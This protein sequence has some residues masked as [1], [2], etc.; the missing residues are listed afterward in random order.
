M[1]AVRLPFAPAHHCWS[2]GEPIDAFRAVGHG[3]VCDRFEC[4][5]AEARRKQAEDRAIE[6]RRR[7]VARERMEREGSDP[8]ATSWSVTPYNEAQLVPLAAWRR[9]DFLEYVRR[10]TR[11]AVDLG[12]HSPEAQPP[13]REEGRF[14]PPRPDE[15][16]ALATGCAT[17]QGRCCRRGGTHAFLKPGRIARLLRERPDLEPEDVPALYES[18]LGAEH[19]SG[20][21]VFQ[22]EKGCRLP[23][24]L[25][26]DTCNDYYCSDLIQV[27]REWRKESPGDTHHFVAVRP[28]GEEADDVKSVPKPGL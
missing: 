19:L 26:G 22:G 11:E 23:R 9:A 15:G 20:G 16:R 17:C 18:H 5:A 2:C 8:D 7:E 28:R 27:R 21:C 4:R 13:D 1:S 12:P 10:I 6:A 14:P 3:G 24:A 25:R